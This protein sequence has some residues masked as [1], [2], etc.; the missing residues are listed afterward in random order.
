MN[1]SECNSNFSF[2]CRVLR[3]PYYVSLSFLFLLA[4]VFWSND[5]CLPLWYLRVLF[6][7]NTLPKFIQRGVI[8]YL[9]LY[10]SHVKI[11]ERIC[12]TVW[13]NFPQ[14]DQ[15]RDITSHFLIKRGNL[16]SYVFNKFHMFF[17]YKQTNV[18]K[19]TYNFHFRKSL[20]REA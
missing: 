5:F 2:Q 7:T 17:K 19:I 14:S 20:L 12:I 8:F 1:L 10:I 18:E 6:S 11:Y 4:T 15:K 13:M 9:D 16:F 3:T